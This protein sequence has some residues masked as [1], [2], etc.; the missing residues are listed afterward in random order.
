M[1]ALTAWAHFVFV[2]PH[3]EKG[4][5]TVLLS[6]TLNTDPRVSVKVLESIQLK[7]RHGVGGEQRLELEPAGDVY[8][9]RLPS[10]GHALIYGTAELGV[11]QMGSARHPF[12][13][14]Y[15]P[16]TVLA[17]PFDQIV[18]GTVPVEIVVR[19]QPGVV[20]LQLL[21]RGCP[22]ANAE[23]TVLLPDGSQKKMRTNEQGETPELGVTSGRIGAWARYWEDTAGERAGKPYQQIRHYATLV[24]DVEQGAVAS[25]QLQVRLPQAV[26]SFGAAVEDGWLYVYGGHIA[27]THVYSTEAV[28]GQFHR[29]KLKRPEAWEPLPGGPPLQGMN[30]AVHNGWIYRIGGMQPRNKPGESARNHS[31]AECARFDPQARRWESLPPLPEPRSS[32]D[33]AAVGD[34][35]VVVGGWNMRG[36]EPAQW[37]KT[38]LVL[39]LS[40]LPMEWRAVQQPFRRRA[41]AAA[42]DARRL[43]VAGGI[44]D[45]GKVRNELWIYDFGSG[46]WKQGPALPGSALHSFAPGAVVHAGRLY[47]SLADGTIYRL[48]ESS[49][50]WKAVAQ[51]AARVSHRLLAGDGKLI[52]A[53]GA[54]RGKNMD[55]VEMWALPDAER[56]VSA[57]R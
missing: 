50:S 20:R 15:Y 21:A 32:H 7:V 29:L 22:Q 1:F 27:P 26:A 6:E 34:K 57:S 49:Q 37:A 4:T 9:V 39:D 24:A 2:V 45:A 54:L 51:G 48:E 16:K 53:G 36:A 31:L 8:Q 56:A 43:F 3:K 40:S 28:S 41:L 52:L 42:A 13:L 23:M 35:L 46:S 44:D 47:V 19:G 30:L 55:L 18:G 14:I 25:S 12:L 17:T 5:A 10:N 38:M 11:T 33:V